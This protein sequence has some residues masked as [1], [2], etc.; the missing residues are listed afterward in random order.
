[1]RPTLGWR[2]PPALTMRDVDDLSHLRTIIGAILVF[3]KELSK[4]LDAPPRV[5]HLGPYEAP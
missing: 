5:F 3:S 1:M 2:S 4:N